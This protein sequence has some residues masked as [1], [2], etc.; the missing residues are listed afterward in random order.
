MDTKEIKKILH[1]LIERMDDKQ[2]SILSISSRD[3]RESSLA[4]LFNFIIL[5]HDHIP[6]FIRNTVKQF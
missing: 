4:F 5:F 6:L 3:F 2:L 1:E